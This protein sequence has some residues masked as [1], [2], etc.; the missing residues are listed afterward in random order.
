[1]EE[2]RTVGTSPAIRPFSVAVGWPW[3]AGDF[4]AQAGEEIV[5]RTVVGRRLRRRECAA[6]G[7]GDTGVCRR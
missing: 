3:P 2:G 6:Q 1:M 4:L 7:G 5:E